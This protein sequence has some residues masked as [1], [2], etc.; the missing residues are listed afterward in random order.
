[1]AC[2]NECFLKGV[3]IVK[4]GIHPK[5]HEVEARCACGATWKTR[6]T[7]NELHLEIE[8]VAAALEASHHGGARREHARERLDS[9]RSVAERAVRRPLPRFAEL[10]GHDDTRN[11][12]DDIGASE[13]LKDPVSGDSP[14]RLQRGVTREILKRQHDNS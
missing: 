2:Y 13:S 5:Y 1:M 10:L 6:S 3:S 4:E 14:N 7:K 12:V 9:C 11:H 8:A